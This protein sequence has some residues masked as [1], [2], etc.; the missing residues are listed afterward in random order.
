MIR[1]AWIVVII[2]LAQLACG[3]TETHGG[4]GGSSGGGGASATIGASSD[5][6]SSSSAAAGA[7]GGRGDAGGGAGAGGA[8]APNPCG[9][10]TGRCD[11]PSA[12]CCEWCW[13]PAPPG[14]PAGCPEG[15][16]KC[17]GPDIY[18]YCGKGGAL[19]VGCAGGA[20]ACTGGVCL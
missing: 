7:V 8:P 12:G 9:E 10:G 2:A 17:F 16:P 6:S 1:A 4:A 19:C 18:S 20:M 5:A 13:G 11:D 3:P 14:D 15:A